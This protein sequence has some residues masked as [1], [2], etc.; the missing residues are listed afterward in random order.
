MVEIFSSS[1]IFFVVL[2]IFF[3]GCCVLTGQAQALSWKSHWMCIFYAIM[4]A[5]FHRFL[6]YGLRGAELLNVPGFILSAVVFACVVLLSYRLV[7]VSCFVRQYSWL[8]E[9]RMI[10]FWRERA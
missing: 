8:Y 10:F 7:R 9:R 4:L 3:L 5:V 6:L 2:T 1:K